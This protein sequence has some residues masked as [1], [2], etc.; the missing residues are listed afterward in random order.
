ME[1]NVFEIGIAIINFLLLLVLL[2]I[3]LFKPL[4]ATLK[5][6]KET[7]AADL[8]A[9]E[10][11]K[12]DME[13]LRQELIAER[14]ASKQAAQEIITRA[15]KTGEVAKN[16][17]IA[18]ARTEADKLIA[19]ARIEIEDEKQKA[20]SHIRSEAADL[21]LSAAS[22]LIGR[23]LDDSDHRELVNKYIEEAGQVQ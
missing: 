4:F 18:E 19:K 22:K 10:D 11:L 9:A 21:A 13:N 17:I 14:N 15:E 2:R 1:L 8:K 12:L 20:L 16:D 6:R 5:K 7:I 23:S 3:F